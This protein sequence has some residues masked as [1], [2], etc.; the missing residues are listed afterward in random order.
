MGK[1]ELHYQHFERMY[2]GHLATTMLGWAISDIYT[3]NKP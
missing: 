1:P 3:T 2:G